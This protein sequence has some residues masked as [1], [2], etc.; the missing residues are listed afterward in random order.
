[1]LFYLLRT[2]LALLLQFE[3]RR[4]PNRLWAREPNPN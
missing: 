2:F 4:S 3:F 1:M